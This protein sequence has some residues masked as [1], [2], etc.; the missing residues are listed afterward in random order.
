M[1]TLD[2]VPST[3]SRRAVAP[4]VRL[5][6]RVAW[7]ACMLAFWNGVPSCSGTD[8]G[9]ILQPADAGGTDATLANPNVDG[10]RPDAPS[11]PEAS[12]KDTAAGYDANLDGG[13]HAA[14]MD[15]SQSSEGSDDT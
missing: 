10:S 14:G 1:S 3:D 5:A 11:S 4:R 9:G 13:D 7:I 12:Q 6:R 8:N 15:V 2:T